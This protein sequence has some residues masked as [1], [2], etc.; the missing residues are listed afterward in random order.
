[1]PSPLAALSPLD[2][3]YARTAD[4][5]RQT[6]S[7]SGLIRYRV[8]VELAWLRALAAAS[9]IK[10]LRPFS[11]STLAALDRLVERFDEGD[12]EK[13][14][15]IESRTNHDVKAIEY[16]LKERLGA[17]PRSAGLARVHPFRVHLGRH[18][19][20]RL[21]ADA[22]RRARRRCCRRSTG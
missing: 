8:Q 16:W 19:Q 11:R 13:I 17:Q 12:A 18:Q 2:G 9:A 4:P 7:E 5:L 21:R 14:K 1:M 6:L 22:R 15:A 3:R 10:G 20:P